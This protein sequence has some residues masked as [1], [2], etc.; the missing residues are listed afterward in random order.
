MHTLY[1]GASWAV[2]SFESISG[3]DDPV[4]TDLSRE[5]GLVNYTFL[6]EYA[7]SNLDQLKCA[8]EFMAQ[9]PEL[10]PFRIVFVTGNSLDDGHKIAGTTQTEFAKYFLTSNDPIGIVKNLEQHFNQQVN[11][12]GVPVA[13]IGAGTDVTCESHENITVIHS[14]WQNFLGQRCGLN[15][16]YG[17]PIN[18]GRTWLKGSVIPDYGPMV[19][20]NLETAPSAAVLRETHKIKIF[21]KTMQQHKLLFGG[22]PTILSNQL[23]AQEIQ[24]SINSWLDKHC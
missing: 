24:H 12:L 17:W 6:A 5:L 3:V 1:V 13:L 22:H 14:S 2:Q 23:F 16:F 20:I 4:K 19:P 18:V 11:A 10:A 21:W 8:Q 9:N 7:K 15:S